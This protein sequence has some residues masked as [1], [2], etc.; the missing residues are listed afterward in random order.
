M[1]ILCFTGSRSAE[2][3]KTELAVRKIADR[4]RL[5]ESQIRDD[6]ERADDDSFSNSRLTSASS[7][8]QT[9]FADGVRHEPC[10]RRFS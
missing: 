3:S 1:A 2:P 10:C 7:T 5:S 4:L 6:L 9:M 8:W